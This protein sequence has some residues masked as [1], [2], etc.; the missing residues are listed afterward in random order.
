MAET[1][2][3]PELFLALSY[4]PMLSEGSLDWLHCDPDCEIGRGVEQESWWVDKGAEVLRSTIASE[5]ATAQSDALHVV[6]LS[7]GLDSGAIVG[8]LREHL[9]SSQL[10]L[11]T[12]GVPGTWDYEIPQLI[13]KKFGLRHVLFNMLDERW[14]PDQLARTA[15]LLDRPVNVHQSYVRRKMVEHFGSDCVFWSG[16]LGE[17]AGTDYPLLPA[18]DRV[19]ALNAFFEV[20]PP[21]KYRGDESWRRVFDYVLSETPWDTLQH[22]KFGLAPHMRDDGIGDADK[23]YIAR[24]VEYGIRDFQNT[25]QIVTVPGFRWKSPFMRSEWVNFWTNVPYELLW[26]RCLYRSAICRAYEDLAELPSVYTSGMPLGS[27]KRRVVVG[28]VLART[29]RRLNKRNVYHAHPRS[30]YMDWSEALR[31]E[32][33]FQKSVLATLDLVAGRGVVSEAEIDRWWSDHMGRRRDNAQ[34]IMNLSSLGLL[35]QAG[36]I[37]RD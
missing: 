15:R 31:R 34:I 20:H 12:F 25:Y 22:P 28:K 30:N 2:P 24:T 37:G 11:T 3:D 6:P 5:L 21:C 10:V 8:E 14:D 29:D 1:I 23:T 19:G 9:P 33:P 17:I 16:F 4:L 27:S 36:K 13:A 7:G 26:H 32:G 18:T 35:L